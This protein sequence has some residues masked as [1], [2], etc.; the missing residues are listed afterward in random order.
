MSITFKVDESVSI[1]TK[2]DH[3]PTT[4]AKILKNLCEEVENYYDYEK[5]NT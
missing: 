5:M 2:V 3:H 1:N 4:P